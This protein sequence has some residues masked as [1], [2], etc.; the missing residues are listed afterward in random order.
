MPNVCVPLWQ[1]P[2]CC[3]VLICLLLRKSVGKSI[4]G[5]QNTITSKYLTE[6]WYFVVCTASNANH[7]ANYQILS[8]WVSEIINFSLRHVWI[9]IHRVVASLSNKILIRFCCRHQIS[10]EHTEHFFSFD[11]NSVW[12][13]TNC[14]STTDALSWYESMTG[15]RILIASVQVIVLALNSR[16]QVLWLSKSVIDSKWFMR[17]WFAL[18]GNH[19]TKFISLESNVTSYNEHAAWYGCRRISALTLR[20]KG[21][22][23]RILWCIYMRITI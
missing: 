9:G 1:Y 7:A 2:S 4:Q 14:Q 11:K 15:H 6:I 10:T 16:I 21:I 12:S 8:T 18:T 5:S 13:P 17:Y 20:R 3:V 23:K 19:R 22:V